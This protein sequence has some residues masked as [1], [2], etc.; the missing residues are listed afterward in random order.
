MNQTCYALVCRKHP[1]FFNLFCATSMASMLQAAHGSVFDTITKSTIN[2]SQI[3]IP[4]PEQREAFE[5]WVAPLFNL[6]HADLVESA[7]L[8]ELRDYLLPRLLSG[9]VRVRDVESSIGGTV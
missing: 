8:A 9:R 5:V 3:C 7:K 1:F 6:I 4:T 2:A